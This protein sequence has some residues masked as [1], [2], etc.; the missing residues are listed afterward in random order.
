MIIIAHRLSTVQK[1]DKIVWLENGKMLDIGIP[2]NIL[3]QY[4][5]YSEH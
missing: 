5:R 4:E 2:S 3:P 1:C